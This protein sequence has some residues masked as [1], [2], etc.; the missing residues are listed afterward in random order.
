MLRQLGIA[1]VALVIGLFA[2]T[3]LVAPPNQLNILDTLMLGGSG[4]SRV[5]EG[6]VFDKATDVKLDVWAPKQKAKTKLPV[7]VFF[8]GGGWYAGERA[9]YA[10]V[11]KAYAAKGFV[12]VMTDYRKVPQ[13]RFPAFNEDGAHAVRWV[14]DNI[15]KFG[16]DPKRVTLAGHS[17]GA[18][19]A[20]ILTLDERYLRDAGVTP[21]FVRATVGLAGAYDFLPFDSVRSINAFAQWPKP[22]ET[23]PI[24][25]ARA[26]APPIMVLTGTHDD[27]VKPRH[28][29]LMARKLR[30][31]GA[32][33]EF[34]AYPNLNHED[35]I[36]AISKPF[37]G[38]GPIL[39][40]S[41]AFLLENSRL[42]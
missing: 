35:L 41:S 10:F 6:V 23:Q 34:K 40:D 29:I 30:E 17:A 16:G 42:N 27:T 25:F 22:I 4:V 12:V 28:A 18:Y 21:G 20:M 24:A 33:A 39:D 1:V 11:G 9:H 19:I 26:D 14:Q 37:L 5:A 8:Y 31:L 3:K 2:F 13:V 32:I 15:E 7:L 38:K 36:M